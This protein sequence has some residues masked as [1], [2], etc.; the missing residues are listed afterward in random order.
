MIFYEQKTLFLNL[1]RE[2]GWILLA[3][4]YYSCFVVSV[5]L[6][7]DEK[8]KEFSQESSPESDEN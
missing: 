5:V 8:C 3:F 6:A 2:S 7:S 1:P 4:C